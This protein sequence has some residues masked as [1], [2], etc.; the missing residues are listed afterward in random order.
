[1]GAYCG[2]Y[3]K[4]RRAWEVSDQLS[5]G[6]RIC[7]IIIKSENGIAENEN[8]KNGNETGKVGM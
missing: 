4:R 5:Y 1:M 6:P 3:N 2:Q 8:V 7:V